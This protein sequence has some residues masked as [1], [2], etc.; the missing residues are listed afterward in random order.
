M[1]YPATE[2]INFR[3][4]RDFSGHINDSAAF[5]RQNIWT[6]L[7]IILKASGIYF[8]LALITLIL[9][10]YY[11]ISDIMSFFS[12]SSGM[13]D[14]NFGFLGALMFTS[15]VLFAIAYIFYTSAVYRYILQYIDRSD[16][17]NI[18]YADI[19]HYMSKDNGNVFSTYM[20]FFLVGLVS[21]FLM[22]LP[23]L[24]GS[25][26]MI[27]VWAILIN[28]S[29]FGSIYLMIPL[30]FI[31]LFRIHRDLDFIDSIRGCLALTKGHWWKTLGLYIVATLIL[32]SVSSIPG[33]FANFGLYIGS[34]LSSNQLGIL[35]FSLFYLTTFLMYFVSGT[36]FS[37]VIAVRYF[38]LLEMKEGRN[39]MDRIQ[40][41]GLGSDD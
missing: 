41:I 4:I 19:K 7:K 9:G 31:Y 22:M 38:S 39:M 26:E 27:G 23:M 18:Q 15:M 10:F 36:A 12:T 40:D 21:S 5:I 13:E 2:K 16:Y 37:A 33:L 32:Y 17:N 35:L 1:N 30:S 6:M 3:K 29:I 8:V 14:I 11:G 28:I 25:K 20:G 24:T 34:L